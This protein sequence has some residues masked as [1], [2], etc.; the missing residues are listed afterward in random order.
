MEFNQVNEQLQEQMHGNSSMD[1]VYKN[2]QKENIELNEL[3]KTY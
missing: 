2:F 3:C 1:E